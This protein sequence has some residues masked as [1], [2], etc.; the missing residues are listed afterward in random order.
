MSLLDGSQY[1]LTRFVFQRA[2]AFIY[3]IGFLI[4]VNQG[5][6]LLGAR[7]LLPVKNFLRRGRFRH[8][9][10]LFWLGSSDRV[11]RA[12]AW[13]GL[14]LAV[15]AMTGV[16]DSHGIVLST[17]VWFALWALYLSFVNVGQTFYGFGWET[18]LLETGFLAIFLGSQD[19]QPPVVVFWLLRW[20]LFR[21][22]FGAGLIKLRGDTCWRDLSCMSY[23]YETQPL[24]NPLSY[25]LHRLPKLVHQLS[26]LF[27]HFV[28]LVVPW[29]YFG[30]GV[31]R[32]I[33]GGLTVFFQ[34]SLILSGNLS[35]LNYITIVITIPCFDDQLLAKLL[36]LAHHLPVEIGW[37]RWGVLGALTLLILWLSIKPAVNLFS[38]RQ[39]MNT[40]FDPLH[41]VNT[42]GAFGSITRKRLELVLEGTTDAVATPATKWHQYEFKAKPGN[43]AR[44]L[45]LVSPYH[46]RLDWQMWFAAMSGFE[47]NIWILNLL[48]KLLRNDGPVLGLLA[49][50]PFPAAPPKLIRVQRYHYRFT[51]PGEGGGRRWHRTL[52]D[53]YLRPLSLRD[54]GFQNVLRQM[55]WLK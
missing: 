43:L 6:P 54:S 45:P 38:R 21:V 32:W 24:P 49:H 34:L 4:L 36:P 23:H 29:G 39:I 41:L 2:L 37:A 11:F 51:R 31:V 27:T 3:V 16:S 20:L 14:A 7:G 18:L 1:Y 13:L 46:Y 30:P 40:S 35:W 10:S 9:P 53:E 42:Y 52:V 15:L 47:D 19:T 25:Y 17:L 28:E 55:H 5:I 12:L 8:S 48:A 44:R 22:M 50:N 26:V 33:A